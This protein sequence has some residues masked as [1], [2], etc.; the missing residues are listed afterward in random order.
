[1]GQDS[2]IEWKSRTIDLR[3]CK[4]AVAGD[5]TPYPDA[6]DAASREKT[7]K[8]AGKTGGCR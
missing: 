6:L 7:R 5:R 1:M 8:K 2:K 4:P 3:G